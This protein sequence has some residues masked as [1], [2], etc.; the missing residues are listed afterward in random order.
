MTLFLNDHILQFNCI[1]SVQRL[2]VRHQTAFKSSAEP[3]LCPAQA[4]MA[5]PLF[6]LGSLPAPGPA[7]TDV[8]PVSTAH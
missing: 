3:Q 1:Y 6:A 8:F 5:I 2:S 7:Q 4:D